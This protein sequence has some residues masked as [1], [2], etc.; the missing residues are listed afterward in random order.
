MILNMIRYIK[1][2]RNYFLLTFIFTFLSSLFAALLQ[3]MKGDLLNSALD[4]K[5]QTII[6]YIILLVVFM[7]LECGF[8]YLYNE[9]R[10]RFTVECTKELQ[11]EYFESVLYQDYPQFQKQKVGSYLSKFSNEIEL[12]KNLYFSNLTLLMKLVVKTV[13]VGIALLSLDWRIALITYILLTM[14]LYIPKLIE[15]RLQKAKAEYVESFENYLKKL[16]DWISHFEPIKIFSAEQK[17]FE[18]FKHHNNSLARSLNQDKHINNISILITELMSYSSHI[19]ILIIAGIFVYQKIFNAGMFFI[20]VSMIDQLSYPIISISGSYQN[21]LSIK[22]RAAVLNDEILNSQKKN[23]ER[24][25]FSRKPISEITF[26]NVGFQ[27]TPSTPLFSDFS[28]QFRSKKRYLII[29]ESGVGKTTLIDLMLRYYV[30]NKGEIYFDDINGKNIK[31]INKSIMV[32]RQESQLYN[33]TLAEN[34]TMFSDKYTEE[35]IKKVLIRVGLERFATAEQLQQTIAENGNDFSGGEKKRICL[36][37]ALLYPT[38]ILILDEPL[39]NLDAENQKII[40]KLI[41]EISDM[42]II[43]VSH[44]FSKENIQKFD[45]ILNLGTKHIKSS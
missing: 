10:S 37:R 44:T 29:G 33:A 45:A 7:L 13:I 17:I 3:F 35:E 12:V 26:K 41:F 24:S 11:A 42:I 31:N 27:Y 19:L 8:D 32:V 18:K 28:Y 16:T 15:K 4:H 21:I 5:E 6:F 40:E 9:M 25:S 43:V 34:I 23:L 36:A 30:P 14:P 20:A 39:A 38:K 1:K 22:N 2:E